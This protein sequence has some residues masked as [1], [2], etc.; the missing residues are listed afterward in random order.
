MNSTK[1][2]ND[3][4]REYV[5]YLPKHDFGNDSYSNVEIRK[6]KLADLVL[7]SLG[8]PLCP[9]DMPTKTNSRE[10]ANEVKA[11]KPGFVYLVR[12]HRNQY[13]KIGW[14][15]KPSIREKTLQSE[16]PELEM[17]FTTPGTRVDERIIQLRFSDK[18]VR[19]EWFN[20]DI[21]DIS[22]IQKSL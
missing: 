17:I 12:N 22:S 10:Q 9:P 5:E 13:T 21:Q 20:L 18:R 15:A 8:L 1:E 3:V 11:I 19:G 2:L 16:E 7:G 6:L 4:I 14:S